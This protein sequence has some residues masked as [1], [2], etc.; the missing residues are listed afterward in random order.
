MEP[1]LTFSRSELPANWKPIKETSSERK[2]KTSH[3]NRKFLCFRR[4]RDID[5][6]RE[7]EREREPCWCIFKKW[8]QERKKLVWPQR[9]H[10]SWIFWPQFGI[11]I[12]V[13]RQ[14]IL[15][16]ETIAYC[17]STTNCRL[18]VGQIELQ[19]WIWQSRCWCW[20]PLYSVIP[21][22]T[23]LVQEKLVVWETGRL[24]NSFVILRPWTSVARFDSRLWLWS[25]AC[26][27]GWDFSRPMD[28]ASGAWP[29]KFCWSTWDPVGPAARSLLSFSWCLGQAKDL[30][31][32]H[33]FDSRLKHASCF[34]YKNGEE[35]ELVRK[36]HKSNAII[37]LHRIYCVDRQQSTPLWPR[38]F[39]DP[40]L[41]HKLLAVSLCFS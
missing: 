26:L 11:Y 37:F 22:C 20:I 8:S 23:T 1:Y 33:W 39:A 34:V 30:K 40:A 14:T 15:W 12:H 38:E 35:P 27:L 5:R 13:H 21:L 7:R 9:K 19:H 31:H 32:H 4:E 2:T 41:E 10:W 18:S 29:I 25:V 24:Y 3:L 28:R 16:Q 17:K 6:E 36:V